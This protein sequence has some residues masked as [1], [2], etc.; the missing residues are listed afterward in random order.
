MLVFIKCALMTHS[1]Q[2]EMCFNEIDSNIYM[3][4]RA[5]TSEAVKL[6]NV[7]FTQSLMLPNIFHLFFFRRYDPRWLSNF[8]ST[9]Y[10]I[11]QNEQSKIAYD[12]VLILHNNKFEHMDVYYLK[13]ID[14][15]KHTTRG[16][17]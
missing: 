7:F 15:L 16:Q 14:Y 8:W 9:M 1:D 17:I 11:T 5:K 2:I 10:S 4:I 13:E 3:E 6:R 12:Y